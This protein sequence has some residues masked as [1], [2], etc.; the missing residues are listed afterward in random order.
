ML[1]GRGW[2]SVM[3]A[4]GLV[5]A[6]AACSSSSS[7]GWMALS[8]N[9]LGNGTVRLV[10]AA[11]WPRGLVG[12]GSVTTG[13][14]RV[15]ALWRTADGR[16]WE[17]LNTDPKS[18]YGF[19]SELTTVAAQGD[20]GVAAIGQAVGGAHGNPRVGSWYLDDSTLKEV[21]APVELYGGPRQGSVNEMAAGP[22]GFV[23]VGT[24]TDRN[25][26][27]GAAAWVSPDAR[28]EFDIVDADPALESGP[29]ETVR[30]L[31]VAGRADGFFAVG[32]RFVSGT[33]HVDA[34][35]LFWSS[36]DGRH[37]TRVAMADPSILAGPGSEEP[38]LVT[39][40]RSGWAVA[41]TDSSGGLTKVVA[42]T[43][44]DGTSW[45]RTDVATLGTDP[46]SLSAVTSLQVVGDGTLVVGARLGTRL[47][48][49]TSADG[50]TWK[51]LALPSG[52]PASDHG[53]VVAA[54]AGDRLVLAA[55]GDAS[56]RV[57]SE[58]ISATK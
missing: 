11:V 28:S 17:R 3:T 8:S 5:I 7:S 27:T 53:L 41:G 24:R 30:A 43:S 6:M 21:T 36:P 26:R 56:T 1:A 40:W 39:A 48:V 57:W 33:G 34:D 44:A 12:V 14:D 37:W 58:P 50:R 13:N 22:T 51:P 38:E 9:V 32:D 23:V 45:Q 25:E 10:H 19:V 35:G 47:A 4:I 16:S 54:P 49:A 52:M 20:G 55:T 46:D 2:A 29:S 18:F 15:P 31:G 42:W